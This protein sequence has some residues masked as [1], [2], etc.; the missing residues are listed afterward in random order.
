MLRIGIIR[1]AQLRPLCFKQIQQLSVLPN[2]GENLIGNLLIG[3]YILDISHFTGGAQ[4]SLCQKSLE[5]TVLIKK[6]PVW[7]RKKQVG[8][9]TWLTNHPRSSQSS[10]FAQPHLLEGPEVAET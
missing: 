2:T 3:K 7:L 4:A 5:F 10:V 9:D 6:I 1:V 8:A